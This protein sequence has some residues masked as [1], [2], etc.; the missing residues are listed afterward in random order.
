MSFSLGEARGLYVR[1]PLIKYV[2]ESPKSKGTH[3]L[4]DDAYI[5]RENEYAL[6]EHSII[7]IIHGR[8][9]EWMKF[10]CTCLASSALGTATG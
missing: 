8:Y 4:P 1:T 7:I 5:N 10:Q 2:N 9:D 3:D 6:I